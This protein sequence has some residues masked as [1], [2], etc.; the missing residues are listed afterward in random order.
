MI[1]RRRSMIPLLGG[2]LLGAGLAG[3]SVTLMGRW[4]VWGALLDPWLLALAL[5][6]FARLFTRRRAG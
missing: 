4:I 1:A 5:W 6:P 3:M 2:P